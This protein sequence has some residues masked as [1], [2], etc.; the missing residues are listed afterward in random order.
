MNNFF[1]AILIFVFI[2]ACSIPEKAKFWSKKNIITE[3]NTYLEEITK[4]QQIFK[5]E[6]ALNLEFNPKLRVNLGENIIKKSFL[7][8][9]HNND[10]RINYDNDLKNI[11]KFKFSKIKEFYDYDPKISFHKNDIIF[12]DNNGT[13]LKFDTNS[14]LIWEK[15]N[16]SKSE[17]KQN[18]ILFFA[19]NNTYLI[20]A[21]NIS[22]YYALDINT[23]EL[24]WTKNNTAPFNS[25]IKIYKD[26]FF[27]IDFENTLKAYSTKDGKKIWEIRTDN[28]LIR[29]QKKLSLVI[30][31]KK[32]YFNNSLGDISAVDI[33]TGELIW[34]RPTQSSLIA[35]G[36]FL[37]KN[38]DI[39]TDKK[40]LYFSN[41]KNQFFSLDVKT[42]ILNWT[43]KINSNLRPILID[44]YLFTVTLEGYFIIIEKN[45]GNIIRINDVFKNFK[46]SKRKDIKP[47]GFIVGNKNI[48]LTTNHGK[49]LL[50]D[51][52]TGV[53]KSI[54]K[55][56]KQKISSP[57]VLNKNL[58]IIT[59]K[60]II[61]LN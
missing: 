45:S 31:D 37:L 35:D 55:I 39:I 21:D 49:L 60:S 46:Q 59:D 61:K 19:N 48:Y 22:K 13:I 32:V 9:F 20:V 33:E 25:Q 6:E 24:L 40:N 42:G 28:S 53:T 26:K 16:Y 17:K 56:D 14:N 15:N 4:Q 1:K 57:S 54:I 3:E 30:I 44:N 10:G 18:P 41:N 51:I 11:S 5:E 2:S 34:Q 7:N 38:S 23:G 50:I 27:V 8:Y 29:S 52:A 12:F 36:G 58:F 43:Q 47:M